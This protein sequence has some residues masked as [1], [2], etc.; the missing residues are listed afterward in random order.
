MAACKYARV[1]RVVGERACCNKEGRRNENN[2]HG[3][4][5]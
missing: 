5:H 4:N 2:F 3:T 1:T